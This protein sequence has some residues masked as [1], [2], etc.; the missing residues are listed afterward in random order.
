MAV[1][2][3]WLVW[4]IFHPAGVKRLTRVSY[5]ETMRA[6]GDPLTSGIPK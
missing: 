1:L 3:T 4:A 5:E 2:T 6:R